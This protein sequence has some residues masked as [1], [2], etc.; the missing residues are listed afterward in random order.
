MGGRVPVD[1]TPGPCTCVQGPKK[2]TPQLRA[3]RDEFLSRCN[4]GEH[5]CGGGGPDGVYMTCI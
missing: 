1:T 4:C 5:N 2:S 3:A